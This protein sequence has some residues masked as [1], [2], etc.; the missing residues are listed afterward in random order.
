VQGEAGASDGKDAA[1]GVIW[2]PSNVGGRST[3]CHKKVAAA[4]A[5][6]EDELVHTATLI[7]AQEQFDEFARLSGD[8]NPIHVDPEFAA[9]TRFGRTVAHGMFL[10]SVTWAEL[11][12]L[13]GFRPTY[14]EFLFNGPTFADEEMML[15][16][17]PVDG[18]FAEQLVN[19]N[20]EAITSGLSLLMEPPPPDPAPADPDATLKGLRIGMQATRTRTF[21]AADVN[22]YRCLVDDPYEYGDEVPGPLLGGFVSAL[23]GVDLPGPGSNWLKQRYTFL[24]PV[25]VDTPIRATVAIVRLRPDKELVNLSTDVSVQGVTA[26]RGESLVLVRDVAG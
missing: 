15:H 6:V 17:T 18:G 11:A 21:T 8:H 14:Q 10:F 25:G 12:R 23:L 1:R 13:G 5:A 24:R 7:F 2:P 16:L 4:P 22:D 3:R 19:P 26:V 9:D 20:G